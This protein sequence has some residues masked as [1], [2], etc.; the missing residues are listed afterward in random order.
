M[1]RI[2]APIV[3]GPGTRLR[4]KLAGPYRTGI[5]KD[6]VRFFELD[7]MCIFLWINS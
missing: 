2:T 7:D 6:Q 3:Q 1:L 4:E 5:A